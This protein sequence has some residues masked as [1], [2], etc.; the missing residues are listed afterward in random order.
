MVNFNEE[1][2]EVDVEVKGLEGSPGTM[3]V[4][5]L[6]TTHGAAENSF[7]EP[8]LVRSSDLACSK[9]ST[10]QHRT[11]QTKICAFWR[12]QGNLGTL[13]RAAAK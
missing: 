10:A 4:T 1:S 12:H 13:C 3:T 11:V 7:D 8:F 5:T 2:Q 9:H 6:N